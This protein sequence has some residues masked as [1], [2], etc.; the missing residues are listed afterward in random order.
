VRDPKERLISAASF[1]DRVVH[2]AIH[3]VVEPLLDPLL[4]EGVY[5]CRRGR[6]NRNA[7][8]KLLRE[9]RRYGR[10]RFVIKL[11]VQSY[12]ASID[13][14]ILWRKLKARLTDDSLDFLF[15][16]LLQSPFSSSA[17][18]RCGI[19]IGNL[20]SQLFAN[21]YLASADA[22]AENWLRNGAYLRYMDDL[23]LLSPSKTNAM[24]AA[25]AVIDHMQNDLRLKV[26]YQKR[27]PLGNGP[28]P[29]LGFVADH[30]GYRVLR[31]NERRFAKKCK[32][33]RRGDYRPSTLARV[34]VSYQAWKNL[35]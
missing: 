6:G 18:I 2:G 32:R 4:S 9:L 34:E 28:V 23:L 30:T 17:S 35:G 16:S 29:F 13:L 11:D 1:R 3:N 31:R 26:P 24:E 33:L 8:L 10:N 19:P 27:V 25:S 22:V 20:T 14:D 5:A 12:F 15:A 21:F 7:V